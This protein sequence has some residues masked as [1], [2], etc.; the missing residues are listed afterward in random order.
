MTDRRDS[1]ARSQLTTAWESFG[2]A[3]ADAYGGGH[4]RPSDELRELLKALQVAVQD[5]AEGQSS[6]RAVTL[7]CERL[8]GHLCSALDDSARDVEL[9]LDAVEA[10]LAPPP[11][12]TEEANS[13]LDEDDD[14][15]V[16]AK[17]V[18]EALE[19]ERRA[20]EGTT[21][22]TEEAAIC[23]WLCSSDGDFLEL[24]ER[25]L[26]RLEGVSAREI[27]SIQAVVRLAL[28]AL[29][30]NDLGA[31][32]DVAA[33]RDKVAGVDGRQ[34]KIR[35]VVEM[36]RTW[37]ARMVESTPDCE[38]AVRECEWVSFL[39]AGIDPTLALGEASCLEL[40]RRAL[41]KTGKSYEEGHV[42]LA[43]VYLSEAGWYPD[44]TS[45]YRAAREALKASRRGALHAG[46]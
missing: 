38:E 16:V 42:K 44:E 6:A 20:L 32:K 9:R 14:E 25:F 3:L 19:R 43:A 2:R 31:I 41:A 5:V 22:T 46:G 10:L 7:L 13:P 24:R 21:L 1:T 39:L 29:R 33:L 23:E 35:R 34:A 27:G 36:L 4:L 18:E 12:P 11:E 30:D 28:H 8:R 37:L 17:L 40:T 26:H 15:G 45:A